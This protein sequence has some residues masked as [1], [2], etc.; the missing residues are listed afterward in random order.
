MRPFTANSKRPAIG[1]IACDVY[2]EVSRVI[3]QGAEE[4]ARE[5]NCDL[6]FHAGGVLVDPVEFCQQR[7]VLYILVNCER[8]DGVVVASSSIVFSSSREQMQA[9]IYRFRDLPLVSLE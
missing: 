1:Y 2:E 6:I 3:W 4:M 7:N 9:F 5:R 8:G